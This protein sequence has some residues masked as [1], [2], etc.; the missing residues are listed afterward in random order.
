MIC[1]SPMTMSCVEGFNFDVSQEQKALIVE[2]YASD[3]YFYGS[4][5]CILGRRNNDVDLKFSSEVKSR[6]EQ[7]LSCV[8][9]RKFR[10]DFESCDYSEP[11]W[12]KE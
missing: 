6:R 12:R 7:P 4:S 11:K 8:E 3:V 5:S 2:R 10:Q 9:I 1:F